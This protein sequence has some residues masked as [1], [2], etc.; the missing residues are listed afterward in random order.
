MKYIY[1]VIPS[2]EGSTS[3]GLLGIGRHE[4]EVYT[5]PYLDIAAVVSDCP[6]IDFH[7]MAKEELVLYL[8][9]HQ[10]ATEEV[11]KRQATILPV[12]FGT[13]LED[14]GQVEE[15]LHWGHRDLRA[16]LAAMEGKIEVEVVA[17]WDVEQVFAEIGQ[18]EEIAKLKAEIAGKLPWQTISAK[19]KLGKMVKASL[20]R[21]KEEHRQRM[22][23]FL[24]SQTADVQVNVASADQVVM[25][26]AL[27]IDAYQQDDFEAKVHQ[28]DERF[29]G[30]L[31]FKLVGPLPPYSFSTVEVRKVSPEEVEEARKLLS[32]GMEATEGEIQKAYRRQARRY[33]PD[34][35]PDDPEAE[36]RFRRITAAY[37]LLTSCCRAQ[38]SLKGAPEGFAIEDLAETSPNGSP[39]MDIERC[40]FDPAVIMQMVLVAVRRSEELVGQSFR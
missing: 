9:E 3:F 2:N 31:N 36:E 39:R 20:D 1:A 25:N 28:L 23:G 40:S 35:A 27:L 37:R 14:E 30:R 12:K 5:Q 18:E 34:V 19:V 10:R 38:S 24:A 7:G 32:L 13:L 21:R 4:A 22:L 16:G 17:T 33:H 8:A 11:M 26:V 15:M 29:E 6:L